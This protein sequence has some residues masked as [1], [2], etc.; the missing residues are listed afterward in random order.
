MLST[1]SLNRKLRAKLQTV[2][3]P[4][5]EELLADKHCQRALKKNEALNTDDGQSADDM[6]PFLQSTN[7]QNVYAE[8][9]RDMK[10]IKTLITI[11]LMDQQYETAFK[12]VTV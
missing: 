9:L 8:P 1:D 7:I 10:T 5:F 6:E 11:A 12:W 3:G 4:V 2:C